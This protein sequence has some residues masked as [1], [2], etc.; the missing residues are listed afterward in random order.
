MSSPYAVAQ[1]SITVCPTKADIDIAMG[2]RPYKLIKKH[3]PEVPLPITRLAAAG[4]L[5]IKGYPVYYLLG[6]N[7]YSFA[8]FISLLSVEISG[9]VII[10]F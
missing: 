3:T 2:H 7:C 1:D 8:A 4:S 9:V 6:A 5:Y 10:L